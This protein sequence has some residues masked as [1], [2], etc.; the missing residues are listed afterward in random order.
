MKSIR[1]LSTSIL[2]PERDFDL[3]TLMLKASGKLISLIGFQ[4]HVTAVGENLSDLEAKMDPDRQVRCT[5]WKHGY[6]AEIG[7]AMTAYGFDKLGSGQIIQGLLGANT[8]SINLQDRLGLLIGKRVSPREV[9]SVLDDA[10]WQ[11]FVSLQ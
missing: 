10:P 7:L 6:E 1:N 8:N 3:R 11:K 4:R 2:C 9:V 5:Y